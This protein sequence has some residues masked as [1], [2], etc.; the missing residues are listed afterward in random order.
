MSK[1]KTPMSPMGRP[2][3]DELRSP[4]QTHPMENVVHNT[5]KI[6]DHSLSPK[7]NGVGR[8]G[9]IPSSPP[10]PRKG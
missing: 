10:K 6:K 1:R 4:K 5:G 9:S 8:L 2:F 3:T 7:G